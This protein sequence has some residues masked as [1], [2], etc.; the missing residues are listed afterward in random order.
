MK[1]TWFIYA[2]LSMI[3]LGIMFLLI[4]Q[5]L[6]L[7]VRSELIVFYQFAISSVL[8]ALF[9]AS[10]KVSFKVSNNAVI[11]LIIIGVISVIGNIFMFRALAGS[12]NP[13]YAL[14]ITNLNT[15]IVLIGG[16]VFF[17]ADFS[18][19]KIIGTILA[20]IGVILLGLK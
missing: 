11:L 16:L 10:T 5:V 14:A 13:G 15:L 9:L 2:I 17:K 12:T 3:I 8:L 6:I 20:I 19:T 7:G 18:L 4:R 1:M